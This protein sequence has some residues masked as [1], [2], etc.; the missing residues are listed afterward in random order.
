MVIP[1]D[2]LNL[3]F[4][5]HCIIIYRRS[6]ERYIINGG[7]TGTDSG[8]SRQAGADLGIL[9]RGGGGGVLGRNSSRGV[10]VQVRR[11]FHILTS[12]KKNLGGGGLNP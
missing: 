3:L 9:R 12:T 7:G 10:R 5:I 11:N 2:I 8:Y 6:S 1:V 4:N